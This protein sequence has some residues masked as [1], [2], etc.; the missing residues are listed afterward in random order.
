MEYI[1]GRELV[2][3]RVRDFVGRYGDK[4]VVVLRAALD[5]ALSGGRKVLG[6]FSYRDL[7]IRLR[8][9]GIEYNPSNILR[10]LERNYG[11]IDKSF[12]SSKQTWYRF[13]DIDA[14]R[15]ALYESSYSG[16][17]DY[18]VRSLRIK[19]RSLRPERIREFLRGL[20]H[21]SS[22]SRYDVMRFRDFSFKDLDLLVDLVE[23]MEEYEDLFR[24]EI[25]VLREILEL[26]DRVA[27]RIEGRGAEVF[28]GEERVYNVD[29]GG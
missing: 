23:R 12:S 19:Y 14:V 20:L 13:V 22:L 3:A 5:I 4:G 7:V 27:S 28:A 1:G 15:E 2:K 24:Q 25:A 11:I 8:S 10:I 26:A 17:E 9:M 16:V 21:K 6:D 29:I 18:R